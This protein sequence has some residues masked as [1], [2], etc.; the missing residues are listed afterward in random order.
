MKL[1]FYINSIHQGGAERV[2]TNLATQF[3]SGGHD[4]TLVTSF[5]D[6]WEY[7]LGEKVK[8]ISLFE[9]KIK[10]AIKRNLLLVKGLRKQIKSINPDVVISFMGE[11]N[12]RAVIANRWL[13]SKLLLSVRSD[14]NKEYAGFINKFL[15]K[16][17]FK[18]ADGVVFQT[19]D[20]K[21][22]FPKKVQD[23]SKIIYNQVALKFFDDDFPNGTDFVTAG[24]LTK[25]KRHDLLIKAFAKISDKVSN[26]LVIYGDGELTD[27]LQSLI[28]ELNLEK[29]V[30][31]A[32]QSRDVLS[33]YKN[34]GIF[35]LSSKVEGMP[36]AL[37]EAMAVGLPCISTDCPC[38]GPK[39]VLSNGNGILVPIEDADA[40]ADAMLSVYLDKENARTLS[41]NAKEK[42]KEFHPAIVY[43]EWEDYILSL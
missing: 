42:A 35:V 22:W 38:G 27:E 6:E 3:S 19:E 15:A 33:A 34:A 8:R 26:N 9:N 43:K 4:V 17:L 21:S 2:I 37:L 32:G 11:P 7:P 12:F 28:E 24:R 20:A 13:K 16:T 1:L 29:R 41:V 36:N 25:A 5:I 14:P 40:L 18:R 23:K 31:L 30:I 10:G 39:A